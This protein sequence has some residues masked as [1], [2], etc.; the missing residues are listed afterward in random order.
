MQ[1]TLHGGP[2]DGIVLDHHDINLYTRFVPVGIHKFVLMPPLNDWDAVRNGDKE[3]DG[4][5]EETCP[6]Y[7]LVRTA[8]G[9]DGRF[10]VDGRIFSEATRTYGEGLQ[11]VPRAEFTG[12][13]FKC[14]RGDLENSSLP[15]RHFVVTDE[16]DR[17]WSCFPVSKEEGE[18]V[19][20]GEML[21]RLAVR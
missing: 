7:E 11:L 2:Y 17:Q 16:K 12:Q 5:F 14:Y 20:L 6:I 10:D 15:G 18:S 19:P 8:Q 9:M 13:Y 21:S 4:Q 3:K 1:A